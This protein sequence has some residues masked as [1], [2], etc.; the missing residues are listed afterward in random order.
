MIEKKDETKKAVKTVSLI[1][2][3]TFFSK[4]LGLLRDI[5]IAAL[6]GN[7]M[8]NS[9][10]AIALD[11][12]SIFFEILFGAAILGVFI[13]VYN[14]FDGSDKNKEEDEKEKFANIFLNFVI[15]ATGFLALIGIIFAP[16]IVNI[17]ADGYVEETKKLTVDLLRI[18]FPA[19]VFTG[20]VFT[21]TGIL[22][23][24]GEF[25]APA[26]VS[27][28][29][30]IGVI[31]YLTFFNDSFGVYG[32]GTAYLISWLIQLLTLVIPLI[33]K[34]YKYKLIIDF[35]NPAF[36]RAVKTALPILAGSWLVPFSKMIINRF[37]SVCGDYDSV[38]AALGKSW[39]LFLIITGVLTYAISNY[40]FPKLAQNSRND[41]EFAKIVRTALSASAFIIAPV[42]CIAFVLKGEA[43][44]VLYM[45]EK[46]TPELARLA[47]QMFAALAPSMVM[48]SLI[49]ILNRTF[50]A[51]NLVK[52]P[53]IASLSGIAANFI[54]CWVFISKLDLPPVYI[55]LAV[56]ICQ[57]IT[58]M[59]LIIVLKMKIKEIFD[60]KFLANVAKIVLSS[61]ILLIIIKILYYIM[62]NN[63][64]ESGMFKNILI[65][66]V[67][68]ITGVCSYI[69][70]N[71][72]FRTNETKEIVKIL[73]LNKGIDYEK[74]NK[75]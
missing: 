14:S 31:I 13:P 24:K 42:A 34:K 30:N 29:S 70:I 64:V 8:E 17:A 69:G 15:L 25:L 16:Q 65:A 3:F 60:K 36:I 33:R 74:N 43:F 45:R 73:K 7:S 61:G 62:K 22:Q 27:A 23:S 28:F 2:L 55:T 68:V 58:A 37:A 6:Y 56:F 41:Q 26:L 4:I 10:L 53:M 20:S 5:C 40:I 39:S 11:V 57:S 50:Y 71:M 51:K 49:E 48:F 12:P 38:I 35:K 44:A 66:G 52:F 72:I 63:A 54:L 21:L 75:L 67:I 18:L 1:M 19:A 46:F 59:I 32:L 47:A 9:A